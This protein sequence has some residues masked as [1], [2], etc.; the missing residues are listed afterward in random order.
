MLDVAIRGALV[1]RGDSLEPLEIGIADGAFE[2]FAVDVGPAHEE[3]RADGLVALPAIID[4][5]V[6]LNEPGRTSWEGFASGSAALAAGGGCALLDMPLNSE[7][8]LLD[9]EAFARKAEAAE[10]SS[11]V[12]VGLWGGLT[13]HNVDRLEELADAGVVGFKAFLSDSGI[14]SFP[15]ADDL[16]LWRGMQ[17]AAARDL[18]VAVHAENDAIT[19][20]L[21]SEAR[22]TGRVDAAAWVA[23]R[24]I[25][26]ETEAIARALHIAEEAGAKLHVVHVSTGQGV[27]LVASARARGVDVTCETCPHYLHFTAADAERVGIWLKC[28]PPVRGA[29]ERAALRTALRAGEVHLVA[30]DHSPAPADLKQG[31]NWLEAWGGVAGI[32]S[33]LTSLLELEAQGEIDLAAIARAAAAA[34]AA[35]FGLMSKGALEPGRDADVTLVRREPE[36]R[37]LTS[38]RLL[39]RHPISPYVGERFSWSVVRT[40]LRGETLWADG[41]ITAR[42]K[43]R[44]LRPGA[45]RPASA[46]GRAGA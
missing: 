46:A 9:A 36:P 10:A 28:A 45:R 39:H 1:L 38:D 3:I 20:A 26:A 30:S 41:R 44:L 40:L 8:P 7:P 22:A 29:A 18:V 6:H 16:T 27:E 13:P 17:V 31:R 4:A 43:G 42:H 12:D 25:L 15:K 2:A 24:P 5:H 32:Q 14:A 34:P 21:A 23:S 33:T 19:S 11:L 35:R 37:P